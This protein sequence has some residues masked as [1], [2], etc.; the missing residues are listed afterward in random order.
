MFGVVTGLATTCSVLVIAR[1][2]VGHGPGRGHP[3][4][5][6]LLADYYPIEKRTEVFGF[7]RMANALG[8]FVGPLVGGLLA[9]AFGWRVPF[10]VFVIPT[11]RVRGPRPAAARSP[12]A[13][14][15]SDEAAGAS[16]GGHRHRRAAAVVG[17]VGPHPLA[18]PDAAAHLVLAAVPRRVGDRPRLASPR[19]TTRRSSTSPSRSGASSPP[20]PSPPSSSASLSGIPLAARLMTARP[21]TRAAHAVVRRGGHRRCVGRAAPWPR[22]WASRS[23]PTS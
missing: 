20:P 6:S 19:S 5:N 4:H 9:E 13:A 21:G 1:S 7:H 15:S 16:R 14:T 11:D 17:R 12:G 23:S 2:G 8:A 22:R 18:G 10:F 3:T